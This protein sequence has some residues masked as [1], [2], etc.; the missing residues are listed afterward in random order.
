MLL[1]HH[2]SSIIPGSVLDLYSLGPM[3]LPTS[4]ETPQN[5]LVYLALKAATVI[6]A[7]WTI[8]D[9]DVYQKGMA[10]DSKKSK[11]K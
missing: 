2:V 5:Q 7:K 3:R 6:V 1:A 4:S 11:M 10:A 9:A 8:S